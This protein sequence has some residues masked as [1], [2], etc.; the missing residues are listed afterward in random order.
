MNIDNLEKVYLKNS[1]LK[2]AV[3]DYIESNKE[4]LIQNPFLDEDIFETN[5]PILDHDYNYIECEYD[6]IAQ[7]ES[8]NQELDDSFIEIFDLSAIRKELIEKEIH[9]II[10]DIDEYETCYLASLISR[11]YSD[12]SFIK[13][14]IQQVEIPKYKN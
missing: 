8:G 14:I 13:K 3:F 9:I 10:F 1:E 6:L 12:G 11:Y 4:S 5:E 2:S 7:S